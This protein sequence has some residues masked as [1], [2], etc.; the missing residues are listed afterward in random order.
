LLINRVAV[1]AAGELFRSAAIN[2]G[3]TW[4]SRNHDDLAFWAP[5]A[6][7]HVIFTPRSSIMRR[8][9]HKYLVLLAVILL[10]ISGPGCRKRT[11]QTDLGTPLPAPKA[12]AANGWP[13]YE[14]P[15][16]G[17]AI[18]LPADWVGMQANPQSFDGMIRQMAANN[19]G[20]ANYADTMRQQVKAGIK[21]FGLDKEAAATGRGTNAVVMR[22][23]LPSGMTLKDIVDLNVE[24]MKGAFKMVGPLNRERKTTRD[25]EC[26]R[27]V[28]TVQINGPAGQAAAVTQ[29]Q[30]YYVSKT[31]YYVVG[32]TTAP[33]NAGPLAGTVTGICESFRLLKK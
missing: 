22:L 7:L 28:F 27:L 5:L 6:Q 16:E 29:T 17:F 33:E 32:V 2:L 23:G 30:Y 14:V 9:G 10:L 11:E 3:S 15:D 20:L 25:G 12:T 21:F 18:A 4:N 13:L 8:D 19:P 26:E 24:Q 31:D 1:C